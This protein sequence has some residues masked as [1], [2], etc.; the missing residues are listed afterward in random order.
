MNLRNL[1]ALGGPQQRLV[2]EFAEK[3]PSIYYETRP[4]ATTPVTGRMIRN[5]DAAQLL[6]AVCNAMPWLAVKRTSLFDSESHS[7]IF[8]ENITADHVVL[9]DEIRQA[10]DLEKDRFPA[11]YR[12]SWQLTRLVAVYLV[13]QLIRASSDPAI[14]GIL[15]DPGAA[16]RRPRLSDDLRGLARFAAAGMKL[17]R[18]R[19]RRDPTAVD[20][21]NVDFKNQTK[22]HE[23][24]DATCDHYVVQSTLEE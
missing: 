18:E 8:A 10:V 6:C 12:K 24:R 5:D 22:L 16:V 23:L 13:G 9:V 11:E 2:T 21:F 1:V 20:A 19:F 14:A 15:A 4:D 17:R 3:Y 7:L